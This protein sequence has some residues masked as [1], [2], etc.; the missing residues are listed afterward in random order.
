MRQRPGEGRE[1]ELCAGFPV[2]NEPLP[3]PRSERWVCSEREVSS[4]SS[5]G[6]RSGL[7]WLVGKGSSSRRSGGWGAEGRSGKGRR[8]GRGGEERRGGEDGSGGGRAC[9][10][11]P[12]A[13]GLAFGQSLRK[14][15]QP[16]GQG[17]S[18]GPV[19]VSSSASAWVST[20]AGGK[21]PRE[22]G[23]GGGSRR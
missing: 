17:N 14:M 13:A 23:W 5:K 6:K 19:P 7:P 11:R 9:A 4:F 12:W 3:R 2:G 22:A 18:L 15:L 20:A 10:L 16:W 8:G 1:A 21:E